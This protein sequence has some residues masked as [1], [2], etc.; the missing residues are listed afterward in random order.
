MHQRHISRAQL[1]AH[2]TDTEHGT[3]H[4]DRVPTSDNKK[5]ASPILKRGRSEPLGDTK[6]EG[7]ASFGSVAQCA[8]MH[9][10]LQLQAESTKLPLS[11]RGHAVTVRGQLREKNRRHWRRRPQ[12]LGD[13]GDAALCTILSRASSSKGCVRDIKVLFIGS[14]DKRIDQHM[15]QPSPG[16]TSSPSAGRERQ[17]SI[18]LHTLSK[19]DVIGTRRKRRH[20]TPTGQSHKRASP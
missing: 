19:E 17:E 7:N 9:T 13:T 5:K 18:S 14:L 10:A 2:D 11:G 8:R 6:S 3:R 1:R 15:D 20:L 12:V 16:D 4:P